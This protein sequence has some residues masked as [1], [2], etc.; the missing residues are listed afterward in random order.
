MHHRLQS[1]CVAMF[2]LCIDCLCSSCWA[3]VM[4]S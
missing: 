2:L 3:F 4:W 1:K